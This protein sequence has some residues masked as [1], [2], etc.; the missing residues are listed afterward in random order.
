M[1]EVGFNEMLL[2]AVVALIVLG[3]E[4][5][6]KAARM[7]GAFVRK[8]RRSWDGLKGELERELEA[9]ELKKQLAELPK[10]A[11]LLQ[12]MSAPIENSIAK[13]NSELH[14]VAQETT[15]TP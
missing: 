3:P 1:F 6:P 12:E 5:L 14:S 9:T 15:K 11:E 2:I 7:A 4:R 10:P 13:M 8:A